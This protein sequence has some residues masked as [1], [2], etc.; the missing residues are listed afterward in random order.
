MH[1]GCQASARLASHTLSQLVFTTRH[2]HQLTLPK[3]KHSRSGS[4]P[5]VTQA[6]NVRAG[7]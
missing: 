5:K 3:G 2:N 4:W 7:I 6:G 1:R